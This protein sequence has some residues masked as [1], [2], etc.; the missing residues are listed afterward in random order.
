MSRASSPGQIQEHSDK[1]ES[2]HQR[3]C[4][5]VRCDSKKKGA[6]GFPCSPS[7]SVSDKDYYTVQKL[8]QFVLKFV[9]R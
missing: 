3:T 1:N 2:I 7:F 6:M 8:Q 5:Q 9:G 4:T